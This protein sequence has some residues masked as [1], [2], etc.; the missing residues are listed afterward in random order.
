M[1]VLW[2]VALKTF[3]L[4]IDIVPNGFKYVID[5]TYRIK[6]VIITTFSNLYIMVINDHI[7]QFMNTFLSD[8]L[9]LMSTLFFD[10][11]SSSLLA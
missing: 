1:F 3:S 9:N 8:S 2:P 6:V 7:N 5:I 4:I 11:H 10:I